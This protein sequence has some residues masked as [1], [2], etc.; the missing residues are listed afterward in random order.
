MMFGKGKP[1]RSLVLQNCVDT[2]LNLMKLR[3][4]L[5]LKKEKR[6]KMF[7]QIDQKKDEKSET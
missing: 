4:E 7:N 1:K 6:K 5:A 3:N 2:P